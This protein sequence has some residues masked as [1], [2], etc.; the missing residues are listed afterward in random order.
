VLEELFGYI[1]E[2]RIYP[3]LLPAGDQLARLGPGLGNG[4]LGE[5]AEPM[6]YRVPTALFAPGDIPDLPAG[7]AEPDAEAGQQLVPAINAAF[8]GRRHPGDGE[9]GEALFHG[10][11]CVDNGLDNA[12]AF[13]RWNSLILNATL[14]TRETATLGTLAIL[15]ETTCDGAENN[16]S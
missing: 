16:P 12:R 5:C 10:D 1:R 7:S 11:P 14:N 8:C 4:Q 6:S 9:I 2:L 13:I 15:A 3:R